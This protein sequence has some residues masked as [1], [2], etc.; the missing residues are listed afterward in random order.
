MLVLFGEMEHERP[1]PRKT[2][3]V[4]PDKVM[5]DPAGR[6]VVHPL[7]FVVG[8]RR[9]LLFERWTDAVCS[10]GGHQQAHGHHHQQGHEACR[11][12]ERARGG[13]TL[14]GF[15][16]ANP[17][18]RLGVAC[19]AGQQFRGGQEGLV[20]LMS[21]E[22]A[23]TLLVHQGRPGRAGRDERPCDRGD[24]LGRL[25]ALAWSSPRARAW[26]RTQ[27]DFVQDRGVE[28]LPQRRQRLLRLRFTGKRPTAAL[29]AR[30]DVALAL[31]AQLLVD[32]VLRLGVA[33]RRVDQH[34]ALGHS[35]ISRGQALRARAR[36]QRGHRLGMGLYERGV[37]GAHGRRDT[38][39][40]L[41]LGLG[42]LLEVVGGI[43][44]TIRHERGRTI[45]RL[46]LGNR[47]LHSLAPNSCASRLLP[48]RG[49]LSTGMPAWCTTINSS[50][51]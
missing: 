50:M 37:R 23:T 22:D 10:G 19:R 43:E 34:P 51:T 13:Q 25:G 38:G 44:G 40:P 42:K 17:A 24:G 26:G 30:G 35:A 20:E 28:A 6:G 8:K 29:L 5:E 27:R 15:E 32:R 31:F 36:A 9:V 11:L 14:G 49:F 1:L 47:V 12:F 41:A 48:L 45:R 33:V 4:H 2:A 7:A 3:P 18:L 16:E 46:S 21:R 39:D